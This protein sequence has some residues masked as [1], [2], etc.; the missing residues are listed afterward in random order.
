MQ[1]QRTK[2]NPRRPDYIYYIDNM[3]K[4]FSQ[5]WVSQG[6]PSDERGESDRTWRCGN[7]EDEEL[8][9]IAPS[10]AIW[11]A[12]SKLT[13][14]VGV[15]VA[16]PARCSLRALYSASWVCNCCMTSPIGAAWSI[17]R[18]PGLNGCIM[19]RTAS[20]LTVTCNKVSHKGSLSTKDCVYGPRYA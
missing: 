13:V 11:A 9:L 17:S 16:P 15:P 8:A 12:C 20:V 3:R 14:A 2:R 5:G 19:C 1:L 6:L 4:I 18:S 7:D 10:S